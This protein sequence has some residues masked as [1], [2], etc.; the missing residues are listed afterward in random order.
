[1]LEESAA[2]EEKVGRW[3]VLPLQWGWGRWRRKTQKF[4]TKR[5]SRVDKNRILETEMGYECH[6]E[7]DQ[8]TIARERASAKQEN[9]YP[10]EGTTCTERARRKARKKIH[11]RFGTHNTDVP[12]TGA[13]SFCG[14]DRVLHRLRRHHTRFAASEYVLHVR[15]TRFRP[16][17]TQPRSGRLGG[18]IEILADPT[19]RYRCPS[20]CAQLE[21]YL[22]HFQILPDLTVHFFRAPVQDQALGYRVSCLLGPFPGL[23]GSIATARMG[24]YA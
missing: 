22:L 1:M 12:E 2:S 8:S 24:S 5:A 14:E 19:P 15:R 17:P 7:T 13:A 18:I 21:K 4:K 3:L 10:G 6:P 11:S 16:L 20:T 23:D 9:R